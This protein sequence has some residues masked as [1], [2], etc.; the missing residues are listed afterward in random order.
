MNTRHTPGPWQISQDKDI[1]EN[2]RYHIDPI[3]PSFHVNPIG[4][5][6]IFDKA[7]DKEIALANAQLIASAPD[8]LTALT[9]LVEYVQGYDGTIDSLKPFGLGLAIGKARHALALA[10]GKA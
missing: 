10:E 9:E 5:V 1:Q 3:D 2:D 8:L 7:E 4:E 6:Y